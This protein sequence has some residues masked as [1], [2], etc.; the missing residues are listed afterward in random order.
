MAGPILNNDDTPK[1]SVLILRFK[2]KDDLK[3]FLKEDP[4]VQVDLFEEV[5]IEVFKK[6]F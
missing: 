6:V 2:T 3:N 1:G 4:Y 5:T